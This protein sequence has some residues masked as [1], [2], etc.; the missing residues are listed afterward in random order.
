LDKVFHH[1]LRERSEISVRYDPQTESIWVYGNP[2]TR[3][4]LSLELIKEFNQLQLEIKDYFVSN[5]MKPKVSIKYFVCASQIPGVYNYGGDLNLFSDLI[6]TKNKDALYQ[7]AKVC[8]DVV[9]LNAVN[10]ELPIT[11]IALVEG[12]ALGGGF[13]AAISCNMVIAE[14]QAQMG[15]P[16]IRF[17]LIPGMGAYSFLA[18][19]VG[20]KVTE[21]IIGSGQMYDAATLHEMGVIT[22]VVKQGEAETAVKKYMKRNIRLFNGMQALQEARRRYQPISYDELIDITKIWVNAAL[23]LSPL[24]LKMMQ[25]LVDAQNAKNINVQHKLRTKQDRR[26]ESEKIIFPFV[27]TEGKVIEKDRRGKPDPR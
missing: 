14:E 11:T 4:C 16:E 2:N 9:Y 18:R 13:E 17:N 5:H 10:L 27:D 20:T 6:K 25:K 1:I 12:D 7:Y 8:I 22:Q 19:L 15:L 26:F 21:E 23:Q 24:D 3:P